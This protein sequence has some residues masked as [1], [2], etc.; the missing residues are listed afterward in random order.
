[1][2][3]LINELID[4]LTDEISCYE[5]LLKISREKTDIIVQGNVEALQKLINHE[6]ELVAKT[7]KF[8]K[9]REQIIED[10]ALVL[11]ENKDTLTIS[12]LLEKLQDNFEGS[13]KLKEVQQKIQALISELKIVN[14]QNR[15][16]LNQSIEMIDY[17]INAIQSKY[18]YS[19]N[20]YSS[21][22]QVQ[23]TEGKS[24]FDAKQ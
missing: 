15:L 9:K 21:S 2:A 7:A 18:S 8:E 22:G 19:T 23:N 5:N 13:K 17:I 10:I 20:D 1:M 4:V 24:F 11:N 3:G 16:L 6:Q 12:K 14:D